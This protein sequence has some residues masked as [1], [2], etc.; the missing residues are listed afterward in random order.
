MWTSFRNGAHNNGVSQ[1]S[2]LVNN[3]KDINRVFIGGIVWATAIIDETNNV[4][5][6]SSNR[7]FICITSFGKIKW[8]Y[9]LSRN[10][11][12]LVDSAAVL[13]PSGLIIIP[14][15]DGIIHALDKSTGIVK[16]LFR[17]PQQNYTDVIVNSFEGNI[18]VNSDNGF[19]YAGSDNGFLYC[20]DG[21]N[22]ELKWSFETKMMIWSC[23]CLIND[24]NHIIFGSLDK[25]VYLLDA[26]TGVI[27]DKYKSTAEIK[28]SPVYYNDK[29]VIC[30]SNGHVMCFDVSKTKLVLYW[31]HQ[32]NSEIYSS[33]AVKDGILVVAKMDGDILAMSIENKMI[34]WIIQVH[35]PFCSSP[36]ISSNNVIFIG[37]SNGKLYAFDL[38]YKHTLGFIDTTLFYPLHDRHYR[39]NLNASPALDSSSVIHIG[40]YDGYIYSIPT[41][42]CL[43]ANIKNNITEKPDLFSIVFSKV[44]HQFKFNI[45]DNSDNCSISSINLKENCPYTI[46]TSSDG[47]YINFI[48]K[49]IFNLDASHNIHVSGK[50]IIQNDRWWKDRISSMFKTIDFSGDVALPAIQYH[51]TSLENMK[52]NSV[53]CWNLWDMFSTQPRV[54]DTYIPA[55]MNSI[56]YTSYAFGFHKRDDGK[57]YFKMILLGSLPGLDN[58]EFLFIPEKNKIILLNA[59]YY[60][61]LCFFDSVSNFELSV[62]GGTLPFDK[63]KVFAQIDANDFSLT[64]DFYASASCLK[65]KGNGETHEFPSDIVNQLCDPSMNV[66]SIGSFKGKYITIKT[67]SKPKANVYF[68]SS[69][70][71]VDMVNKPPYQNMILTIVEY[72]NKVSDSCNLIAKEVENKKNTFVRKNNLRYMVILNDIILT[73]I[74]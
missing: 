59:I 55:A 46:I 40:G 33:P 29:V 25:F 1:F 28:S 64:C 19:I 73:M 61:G 74:N 47:K 12:S 37:C 4:Y 42:L 35:S 11:D 36:I 63:F 24:N 38:F 45:Y 30:N 32:F 39:K 68:N 51:S 67:E 27:V 23:P 31:V 2:G 49:D 16:W 13:H 70:I 34:F 44:I 52:D 57:M 17:P 22:G 53:I 66:I 72:S 56:G 43:K 58:E 10:I 60:R 21:Y 65:I 15:G 26:N 8:T 62:M 50:Y 54:L 7:M 41:Y 18:Q 20:I 6:G 69:S 71:I 14:G 48:P 9:K 5:V 3:N